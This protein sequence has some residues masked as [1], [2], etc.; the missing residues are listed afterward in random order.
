MPSCDRGCLQRVVASDSGL[1]GCMQRRQ[2]RVI[3]VAFE[4]NTRGKIQAR[5]RMESMWDILIT[6]TDQT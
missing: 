6:L 2:S 1:G 3:E 4:L 5:E